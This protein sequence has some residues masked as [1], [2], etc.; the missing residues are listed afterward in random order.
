MRT[1]PLRSR[2]FTLIEALVV[3][4][5][6][7][8][9]AALAAPSMQQLSASMRAKSA[10]FDLI[11]DL[12]YARSEAL[13][14]NTVVTMQPSTGTD[15]ATGWQILVG[16]QLLR[17]REALSSSLRVDAPASLAF[18]PNGRATSDVSTANLEWSVTSTMSGVTARCIV[19]T[20]TGAARSKSGAC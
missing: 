2:G 9:L 6:A 8:I 7:G 16:A 5:I 18:Q 12:A 4:A 20:P 10:A 13:K 1:R 15:W 14:R 3:I 11:S 19:I 17:Q